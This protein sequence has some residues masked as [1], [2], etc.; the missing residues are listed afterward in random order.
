[1]SFGS[2]ILAFFFLLGG[3]ILAG[4]NT[5]LQHMGRLRAKE[6]FKK[7]PKLFFF[8]HLLHPL[9]GKRKWEGLFLTLSFAK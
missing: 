2:I 5:A 6:E 4:T 8:Q 7:I 9:F 1:M 3:A